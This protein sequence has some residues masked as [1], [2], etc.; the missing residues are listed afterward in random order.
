MTRDD[1]KLT[2]ASEFFDLAGWLD[3]WSETKPGGADE[4]CVQICPACGNSNFKLY[5]NVQKKLWLCYVC[6]WGRGLRDMALLMTH[7]SGQTML[8]VRL[9]IL[10]SLKPLAPVGELSSKLAAM[11]DAKAELEKPR[12]PALVAPGTDTFDG[13]VGNLVLGY[14]RGRGLY[15]DE[16]IRYRLRP[17]YKLQPNEAS[18]TFK[19]PFLV[20]PNY[21]RGT[22]VSWQ[23][24]RTDNKSEPRYVSSD[25]V[26]Q[27]LWPLDDWAA[28]RLADGDITLVEGTFDSAGLWRIDVPAMATYGKKISANQIALL[29]EIGAK[30][31]TLAW[32]ADSARTSSARLAHGAKNLRGEIEAAAMRLAAD[33]E[34]RVVDFSEGTD[35]AK[36][37]PGDVLHDSD[38]ESWVRER[39][40]AAMDVGSDQFFMWRLS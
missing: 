34:V 37:D 32:D 10:A 8:D 26:A 12:L 40:A 25:A 36:V 2:E 31:I 16:I 38:A 18:R 35:G 30:R 9:E 11:F 28:R 24:R 20:F 17:T 21:H 33:F 13:S 29:H 19:G 39:L 27:W 6:D 4:V 23:G 14:A 22:C 5:V 1:Y 7:I 15:D 3:S